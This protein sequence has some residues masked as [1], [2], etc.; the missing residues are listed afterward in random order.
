[1]RGEYFRGL[2]AVGPRRAS[3]LCRVPGSRALLLAVLTL[4]CAAKPHWWHGGQPAQTTTYRVN[5]RIKGAHVRRMRSQKQKRGLTA[6]RP[7]D[8]PHASP[9]TTG[10]RPRRVPPLVAYGDR[11]IGA[12][13]SPYQQ[14]VV[15][16]D[17]HQRRQQETKKKLPP[18]F[19]ES[20]ISKKAGLTDPTCWWAILGS[21]Q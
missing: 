1:M 21:N 8:A 14:H 7:P 19:D 15:S 4:Q 5:V 2:A 17:P 18:T 16:Y 3:L 11:T 6:R 13:K 10:A 20:S 12:E 9:A